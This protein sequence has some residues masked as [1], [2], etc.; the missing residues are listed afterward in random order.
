MGGEDYVIEI[1]V[2]EYKLD[3]PV[4]VRKFG[5]TSLASTDLIRDCARLVH[6]SDSLTVV[7]VS[8]MAG[9]TDYLVKL[10]GEFKSPKISED[11]VVATGEQVSAGLFSAALNELGM[12]SVPLCGWHLPILVENSKIISIKSKKIIDLL[13]QG[14]T[15]V[16]TGFQGVDKL[17]NITTMSRGGSDTTAVAIAAAIGVDCEIYTDVNGIYETDPNIQTH[18]NRMYQSIDYDSMLSMSKNGAK[19]MHPDA[20][21]I[22]K[23]NQVK[24]KVLSPFNLEGGTTIYDPPVAKISGT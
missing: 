9:V 14:Y 21:L 13:K 11:M 5:G 10:C 22:A 2:P 16:I 6:D 7:V 24:I 17:G 15:P 23:Y 20:V 4:Y 12:N 8:A 3:K 1:D 18:N 19:V